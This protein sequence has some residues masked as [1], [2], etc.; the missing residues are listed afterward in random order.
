MSMKPLPYLHLWAFAGSIGLLLNSCRSSGTNPQRPTAELPAA[1]TMQTS[2]FELVDSSR[3]RA[4]PVAAY[5]PRVAGGTQLP[6]K[7]A[8]LNPGYGLS[9]T[10]Y[11]FIARNLVAHG[12]YVASLQQQLPGDAPIPTTG[13]IYATRYPYWNQGAQS[14]YFTL[15]ALKRRLPQLDMSQVLLVGHSYGGDM[16]MLFARQHPELARQVISLD[17]RRMPFPRTRRPVLLS[18]RSSDQQPDA[19]VLPTPAE[20]AALGMTV[21]QLAA[22]RHDDMTDTGTE[23]SSSR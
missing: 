21:V 3:G 15:G 9:N 6:R 5:F 14:I 17:N 7:L 1:G 20:Q 13:E 2:R 19:G 16:V 10:D 12:Y 4:I 23:R 11:T 18:L 8:L 22:T